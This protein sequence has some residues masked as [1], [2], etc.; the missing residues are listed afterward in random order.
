VVAA[1]PPTGVP[2]S[3]GLPVWIAI[4][5]FWA[6]EAIAVRISSAG[7]LE[8]WRM[9]ATPVRLATE[10]T[11]LVNTWYRIALTNDGTVNNW[12]VLRIGTGA[13]TSAGP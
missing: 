2:R 4:W 13:V 8:H 9:D 5:N 7:R 10:S 11:L 6:A 3:L 1:H 12:R